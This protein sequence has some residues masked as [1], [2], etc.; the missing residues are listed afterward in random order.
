[1]DIYVTTQNVS[2]QYLT[3]NFAASA[4]MT[5]HVIRMHMKNMTTWSND[6]SN[7]KVTPNNKPNL[8]PNPNHNHNPN[9]NPKPKVEEEDTS[10]PEIDVSHLLEITDD[11]VLKDTIQAHQDKIAAQGGN[12]KT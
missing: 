7:S 12:T 4:R 9:S 11:T 3:L 1:M 8:N 2:L 5:E 6:Y 10:I